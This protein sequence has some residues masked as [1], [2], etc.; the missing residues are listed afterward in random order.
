MVRPGSEADLEAVSRI[1][2]ASPETARWD[3]SGY[4]AY[5]LL[6][7]VSEDRVT[8]FAVARKIDD[9]ESEILNLAVDP[10]WRRQG[11][12]RELIDKI[13]GMHPGDVFLEVRESNSGARSFYKA[14]GFQ[15]VSK[16]IGYYDSPSESAIVMKFHSC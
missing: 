12:A 4:L 10:N 15:E 8:G 16:R 1:Q 13:C 5:D 2:G 14:V 9:G 11:V 6:V 7:A 3:P